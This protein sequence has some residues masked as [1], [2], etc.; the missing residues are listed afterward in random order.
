M[1]DLNKFF[2]DQ[3]KKRTLVP[4]SSK[5]IDSVIPDSIKRSTE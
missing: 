4:E 2:A 3:M 5:D 1:K